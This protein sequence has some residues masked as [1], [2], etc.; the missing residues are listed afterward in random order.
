METLPAVKEV[1]R[2][3][4]LADE[5]LDLV[6]LPDCSGLLGPARILAA[7]PELVVEREEITEK[8]DRVGTEDTPETEEI[9]ETEEAFE[10]GETMGMLKEDSVAVANRMADVVKALPPEDS[11]TNDDAGVD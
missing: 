4:A 5:E 10:P 8:G 6:A 9:C 2:V 3:C 1:A 11:V 7:K